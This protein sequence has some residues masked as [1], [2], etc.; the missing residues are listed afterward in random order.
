MLAPEGALG[1]QALNPPGHSGSLP[2]QP[3]L[4]EHGLSTCTPAAP[5]FYA[6]RRTAPLQALRDPAA[7]QAPAEALHA[8]GRSLLAR[9]GQE[10]SVGWL[11]WLT[12]AAK[13]Q[14]LLP[15]SSNHH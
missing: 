14:E 9:P 13:C 8:R 7:S 3:G 15:V 2:E 4:Q 11:C 12:A 10:G 6:E 1:T 5:L